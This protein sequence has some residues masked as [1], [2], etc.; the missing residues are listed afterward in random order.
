MHELACTQYTLCCVCVCKSYWHVHWRTSY[1]AYKIF[2]RF[3]FQSTSCMWVNWIYD[4][5]ASRYHTIFAIN[6]FVSH[7]ER[8][9]HSLCAWYT[10]NCYIF[11]ALSF[12]TLINDPEKYYTLHHYRHLLHR[13]YYAIRLFAHV[14]N[15]CTF[16]DTLK[17]SERGRK[18]KYVCILNVRCGRL[19]WRNC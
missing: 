6:I 1:I 10:Q 8:D 3:S 19:M 5:C 15:L 14:Q 16:C 12:N 13:S 17:M 4:V 9:T 2:T 18:R 11:R 7:W